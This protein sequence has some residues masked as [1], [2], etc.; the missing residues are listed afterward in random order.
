MCSEAI[1]TIQVN[2]KSIL[3]K[4]AAKNILSDTNQKFPVEISIIA[5]KMGF[6][7]ILANHL[8]DND[9]GIIIVGDKAQEK[10]NHRQCVFINKYMKPRKRRFV[11]AHEIGHYLLTFDPSQEENFVS[12][13]DKKVSDETEAKVNA[14]A[15]N[16]LM[17]EEAFIVKYNQ[18]KQ[19]E[20]KLY[21]IVEV[22]ADTFG[23]TEKMV[24]NRIREL[25]IMVGGCSA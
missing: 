24:L 21:R 22:L 11:L 8:P 25:E 6:K 13:Y 10:F 1:K 14:F 23:V 4:E 5:K 2:Q 17:P 19:Q 16:L 7:V 3:P 12:S 9:S 20:F 15:T 18:L